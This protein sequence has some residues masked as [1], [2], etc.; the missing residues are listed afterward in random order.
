MKDLLYTLIWS[1]NGVT[2]YEHY[3]KKHQTELLDDDDIRVSMNWIDD[4][5][6]FIHLNNRTPSGLIEGFT[7]LYKKFSIDGFLIDPWKSVKQNMDKRSDLWMED[8][9]MSLKEFSLETD[10][11]MSF[12]VHPK[13][14]RDYKDDDGN[15]REI[16]PFD[17]NGGAAWFNSMDVIVSLRKRNIGEADNPI[18]T[19][20]WITYKVRKQHLAGRTGRYQMIDFNMDKYRFLFGGTDPLESL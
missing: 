20:D 8:T 2:P 10:S 19:T 17:L 11:I 1:L 12:I 3:A 14:L 16:T 6:K 13:A 18:Y 5:F 4:H 15:Y 9:L 7:A